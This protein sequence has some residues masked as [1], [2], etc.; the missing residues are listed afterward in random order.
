LVNEAVTQQVKAHTSGSAP[1]IRTFTDHYIQRLLTMMQYLRPEAFDQAEY[2]QDVNKDEL[3]K[4]LLLLDGDMIKRGISGNLPNYALVTCYVPSRSYIIKQNY[5]SLTECYKT[6]EAHY[7]KDRPIGHLVFGL[8]WAHFLITGSTI[9]E[10]AYNAAIRS[11]IASLAAESKYSQSGML[12]H[13]LETPS[14]VRLN[15]WDHNIISAI[16]AGSHTHTH[17]HITS[18]VVC[19]PC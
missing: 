5:S 18:L 19:L 15:I 4:A 16:Y 3:G 1:E 13:H 17:T 2:L 12:H 9:G 11:L 14:P 10:R 6:S 8:I 7:D